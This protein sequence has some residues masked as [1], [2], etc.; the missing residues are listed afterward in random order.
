MKNRK[1]ILI[2]S[3]LAVCI[4][5]SGCSFL[6]NKNPITCS[7]GAYIDTLPLSDVQIKTSSKILC[8]T[9]TNGKFSFTDNNSEITIYAEKTGYLFSPKE[10]TINKNTENIVFTAKRVE[11]LNGN[12]SLSKINITPSSIVSISENYDYKKDNNSC[13]KIK[14]F[15]LSINDK[16][17]NCLNSDFYAIK[18]KSNY[19]DFKQDFTIPTNTPFK[20]KF[21]L[22]TYF[23]LNQN[24][25]I[26]IEERESVLNVLEE[27][28]NA[29]LN[30][31]NQIEYTIYGI[32]SSN[33]KFSYSVS[34]IFDYFENI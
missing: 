9:D 19:I 3:L 21:H 2:A 8:K 32:N 11:K 29:I 15:N 12:L 7:G 5:L 6:P 34:F 14:N 30:D 18:N 20:I 16:P 17:Y 33:N 25:Y 24:E 27:Q 23:M 28:T 22:D 4:L 10:I 31:N 1:S 13:L 26:F